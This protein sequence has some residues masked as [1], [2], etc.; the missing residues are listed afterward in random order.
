MPHSVALITT[1][2]TGLGLALVMGFIAMRLK[3]P[4]PSPAAQRF[5]DFILGAAGL[6]RL[7]EIGFLPP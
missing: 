3:L 7:A 5:V 2:A 1:L 4:A 6:R